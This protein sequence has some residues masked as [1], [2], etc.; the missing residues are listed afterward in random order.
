M[1]EHDESNREQT[2]GKRGAWSS[3]F[4]A[5]FL[6]FQIALPLAYYLGEDRFDERFAWRMFSSVRLTECEMRARESEEAGEFDRFYAHRD[7]QVAWVRLIE[8]N[9]DRVVRAYLR[10]RCNQQPVER[11]EVRTTCRAPDG[12]VTRHVWRNDCG[13]T[14][15]ERSDRVLDR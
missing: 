2:E 6:A 15:V 11:V 3:L 10:R 14:N 4:I 7:I 8:R 1:T 5:G 12:V 9:R 13:D